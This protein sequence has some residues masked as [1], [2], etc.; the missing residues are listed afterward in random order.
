MYRKILNDLYKCIKEYI[1]WNFLFKT[2]EMTTVILKM[3][4]I[5]KK[6]FILEMEWLL[7][8]EKW[9]S[10]ALINLRKNEE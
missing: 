5:I 9:L 10:S 8:W 2:A 7:Q 1:S 6:Y 3:C 4:G